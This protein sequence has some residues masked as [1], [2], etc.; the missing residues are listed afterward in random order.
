MITF[1]LVLDIN[2]Y[3]LPLDIKQHKFLVCVTPTDHVRLYDFTVFTSIFIMFLLSHLSC[4]QLLLLQ[5][6]ENRQWQYSCCSDRDF[7]KESG[8][9][10]QSTVWIISQYYLYIT[11]WVH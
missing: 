11:P 3:R 2:L 5:T 8:I 9:I 1:S 4:D 7:V 10:I 6:K